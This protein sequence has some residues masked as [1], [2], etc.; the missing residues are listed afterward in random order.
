MD[1][2]LDETAPLGPAKKSTSLF[3]TPLHLPAIWSRSSSTSDILPIA[4]KETTRKPAMHFPTEGLKVS[5]LSN[6]IAVCG[7][8]KKI[9]YL[10]TQQIVEKCILPVTAANKSSYCELIKTRDPSVVSHATA[11]ISHSWSGN[12]MDTYRAIRYHFRNTPDAC[13]WID[14]FC[15][16]QR[17]FYPKK[18]RHSKFASF[19]DAAGFVS[20]NLNTGAD[21]GSSLF[22]PFRL[23]F[24]NGERSHGAESPGASS[25]GGA[26][27]N[28]T[29]SVGV[30]EEDAPTAQ[31]AKTTTKASV[32][33]WNG[34]HTGAA[35]DWCTDILKHGI[36][37]IGHVVLIV[38]PNP[39]PEPKS[40]NQGTK[41][42]NV[43]G[44][45][46][47]SETDEP[48]E[49]ENEQEAAAQSPKS[50]LLWEKSRY[51]SK[52]H[53]LNRLWCLYEVYCTTVDR[54]HTLDVSN[55]GRAHS[56]LA[57]EALAG[58]LNGA[59]NTGEHLSPRVA[60]RG[61]DASA[62]H[63]PSTLPKRDRG[64]GAPKKAC[65]FDIAMHY[66]VLSDGRHNSSAN[67]KNRRSPFTIDLAATCRDFEH[68]MKWVCAIQ[69]E[70]CSA[71]DASDAERLLHII[72]VD[73][74]A[75]IFIDTVR[76]VLSSWVVNTMN[77]NSVEI[78][79]EDAKIVTY[80]NTLLNT[81]TNKQRLYIQQVLCNM[82]H[83]KGD[84]FRAEGALIELS[85]YSLILFSC[86]F[87]SFFVSPYALRVSTTHT[88]IM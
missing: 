22:S 14:I 58:G 16:D 87:I 88:S 57:A 43:M 13:L 20:T 81:S 72:N 24:G 41:P 6:F 48:P 27:I 73:V 21:Q 63:V 75:T 78:A 3:T 7:G 4:A 29:Y 8:E 53:A 35:G 12:F 33:Q 52:R 62:S 84:T 51:T 40:G 30:H 19:G 79:I 15:L 9:K 60:S 69:L 17:I 54:T 80:T 67:V 64:D 28:S 18:I 36:D 50:S 55:V 74:G 11:Y 42:N 1:S 45:G 10:T 26:S 56:L 49:P 85:K 44:I 70:N 68:L 2:P 77:E 47:T 65:T 76:N 5:A 37:Q 38:N 83:V 82:F 66:S 25:T 46:T 39:N 34:L 71:S 59:V 31:K 23:T 86:R 61:L 32:G